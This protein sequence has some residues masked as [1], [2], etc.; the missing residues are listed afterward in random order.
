VIGFALIPQTARIDAEHAH[1]LRSARIEGPA[2][3]RH[4]PRG[5]EDVALTQRCNHNYW[6]A[7][8][9]QLERHRAV[10]NQVK[11]IGRFVFSEQIFA[12]R[13]AQIAGAAGNRGAKFGAEAGEKRMLQDDT[14]KP[15]HLHPS[16][17][18]PGS[19]G[20]RPLPM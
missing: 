19:L 5:I 17:T 20:S 18:P 8:R 16:A 2:I 9:M 3:G 13:K 10:A 1:E 7:W 14:F 6:L 12:R 4:E 11:F 15:L